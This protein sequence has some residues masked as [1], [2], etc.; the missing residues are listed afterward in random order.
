M[1]KL[2]A[3]S[4]VK[5]RQCKRTFRRKDDDYDYRVSSQ[6]CRSH[7]HFSQ[8]QW[9]QLRKCKWILGQQSSFYGKKDN[10]E[11]FFSSN[12]EFA[13]SIFAF[14]FFF[15]FKITLLYFPLY[16]HVK[17]DGVENPAW[18]VLLNL[19]LR[20][21]WCWC[22]DILSIEHFIDYPFH[23][24]FYNTLS[25]HV[26]TQFLRQNFTHTPV[27]ERVHTNI[28]KIYRDTYK[29]TH[30]QTYTHT[31]ICIHT[32]IHTQKHMHTHAFARVHKYTKNLDT[33]KLFT[34]NLQTQ[35]F[36]MKFFTH[37]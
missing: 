1:G 34:Q 21:N 19:L 2:S 5:S 27:F 36:F 37:T 6:F 22:S 10:I 13:W 35:L 3:K 31:C 28:H 20:R 33:H 32:Y 25:K 11:Y 16:Q 4:R 18:P 17:N 12:G 24:P 9:R 26:H 15:F 7:L 30:T 29:L 8:R 23:K 14:F